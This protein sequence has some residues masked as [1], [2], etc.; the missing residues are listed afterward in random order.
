VLTHEVSRPSTSR[1]SRLSHGVQLQVVG[2]LS[3]LQPGSFHLI[4][5]RGAPSARLSLR[6]IDISIHRSG[7][8]PSRGAIRPVTSL[9]IWRLGGSN[10]SRR[11]SKAQLSGP[12][13]GSLLAVGPPDCDQIETTFGSHSQPGCDHLQPQSLIPAVV[14]SMSVTVEAP[15]A[16]PRSRTDLLGELVSYP[17]T[18]DFAHAWDDRVRLPAPLRLAVIADED[19]PERSPEEEPST[20][21]RRRAK[22]RAGDV[23]PGLLTT[24][25]L[26]V[27]DQLPPGLLW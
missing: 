14:L 22:H 2:G 17:F 5:D 7:G 4:R 23:L 12:V 24:E 3:S 10:P 13:T 26:L 21:G 25:Y 15:A 6:S 11:A 8:L 1:H 19:H 18:S 20:K 16:S 9:R 27:A